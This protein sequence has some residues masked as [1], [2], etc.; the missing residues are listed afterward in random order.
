[1]N[2]EDRHRFCCC[3]SKTAALVF[4]IVFAVFNVCHFGA[5]SYKGDTSVIASFIGLLVTLIPCALVIAGHCSRK[6]ALYLLALIANGVF[7]LIYLFS[8]VVLV[9]F[10]FIYDET[11]KD[12]KKVCEEFKKQGFSDIRLLVGILIIVCF[13][14]LLLLSCFEIAICG[15][16]KQMKAELAVAY[17]VAP[18]GSRFVK[19]ASVSARDSS[20]ETETESV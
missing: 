14:N 20:I 3:S 2:P 7:M 5:A 10:F 9:G 17:V 11:N 16:Y 6:P 4:A 18:R 1:M 15:G 12:F 13:L 8:I 19:R